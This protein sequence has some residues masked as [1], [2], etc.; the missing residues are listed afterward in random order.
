MIRGFVNG[1]SLKDVT[2]DL[3][4]Q[5]ALE[6]DSRQVL[7]DTEDFNESVALSPEKRQPIFG[8]E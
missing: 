1:E 5:L 7:G 8:G 6:C 3:A 2:M 4:N